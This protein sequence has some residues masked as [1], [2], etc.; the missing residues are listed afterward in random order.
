MF[1]A[2]VSCIVASAVIVSSCFKFAGSRMSSA[3]FHYIAVNIQFLLTNFKALVGNIFFR[4][5]NISDF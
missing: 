4:L 2:T 1:T 5:T 3:V